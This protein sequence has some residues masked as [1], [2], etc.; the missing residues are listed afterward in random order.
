MLNSLSDAFSVSTLS[1]LSSSSQSILVNLIGL[2]LTLFALLNDLSC[3]CRPYLWRIF[4]V[5][6]SIVLVKEFTSTLLMKKLLIRETE[7]PIC[8]CLL[9]LILSII[10][11]IK[12]RYLILTKLLL[13]HSVERRFDL[14]FHNF[15][16]LN[17]LICSVLSSFTRLLRLL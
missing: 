8:I 15:A 16:T 3:C 5:M 13:K 12:S 14:R 6:N 1:L 9:I 11:L 10:G 2:F 4:K 7:I 17:Q